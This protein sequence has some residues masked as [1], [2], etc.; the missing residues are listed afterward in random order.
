MCGIRYL[1]LWSSCQGQTANKSNSLHSV[2]YLRPPRVHCTIYINCQEASSRPLQRGETRWDDQLPDCYLRRWEKWQNEL[3]SFER[4]SYPRCVKPPDFW[5]VKSRQLQMFS[6]ASSIGYGSVVYQRP[7]D[8]QGHIHCLF[9]IGKAR[10][11]PIKP[12]TTPHLEPTAASVSIC[13]GEMMK[14]ELNDKP[15]T[16][17]YHTDL[18]TV[19]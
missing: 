13:L 7:C 5:E 11:A 4:L 19:L 12:V 14:K 6:D 8:N 3:P 17:Q 10:L 18:T 15:D 1:W 2:F 16:I 9:L